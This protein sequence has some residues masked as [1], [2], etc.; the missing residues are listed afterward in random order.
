M[1]NQSYPPP[2]P[3][4]RE[5]KMWHFFC[6]CKVSVFNHAGRYRRKKEYH[7]HTSGS[8]SLYPSQ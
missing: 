2:P 1:P 5:N 6:L 3:H 7:H 4:T 8:L